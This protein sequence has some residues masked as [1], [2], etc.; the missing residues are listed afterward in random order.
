MLEKTDPDTTCSLNEPIIQS[1]LTKL[2]KEAKKDKIKFLRVGLSML[3]DKILKK[4][5][6]V[7]DEAKRFR[8]VYIPIS[9]DQGRFAYITARSIEAQRIVEFG[10]SF[11]I[12]TIYLAAAVRDNGGELVIGSEIEPSKVEIAN[13][14]IESAGLQNYVNIR[15][16]DAQETLRDPGG[17][18]DMVLLDGWKNLYLPIIKML[19]PH[20]RKGAVVLADNVL[21]LKKALGPYVAHMQDSHNGFFSVTLPIGHGMEYSVKL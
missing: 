12:S 20:L 3:S 18:V 21:N 9:P 6:T 8:D 1:I 2:H 19:T 13:A 7:T 11:G 16:G 14:N 10:T 4:K 17:T 5:P 15:K